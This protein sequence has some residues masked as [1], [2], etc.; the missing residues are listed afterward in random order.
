M[1]NAIEQ[2]VEWLEKEYSPFTELHAVS[3]ILNKARSLQSQ[4]EATARPVQEKEEGLENELA[5]ALEDI[6]SLWE[7]YKPKNVLYTN[8]EN[9]AK[10]VL[11]KLNHPSKATEDRATQRQDSLQDQLSDVRKAANRMGCYDAEAW[12]VSMS[13][14]TFNAP[15]NPPLADKLVEALE[16][17]HRICATAM[18]DNWKPD[19]QMFA[20]I[21]G[22]AGAA[23]AKFKGATK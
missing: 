15:A 12:I 5:Q 14:R 13:G 6:L 2:M 18:E 20:E 9:R 10:S 4:D 17:I 19:A 16:D 8:R 11:D 1:K 7:C 3:P 23:L 22:V 21:L